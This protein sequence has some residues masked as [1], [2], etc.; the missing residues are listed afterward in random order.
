M[1]FNSS[2]TTKPSLNDN[3]SN[4]K[5]NNI[6]TSKKIL[7]FNNNFL[8]N[9]NNT[10]NNNERCDKFGNLIKKNGKQK[11]SFL[12]KIE[13]RRICEI[14]EIESYKEYNKMNDIKF[15]NNGKNNCCILF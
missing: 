1:S 15:N 11:I 7:N 8:Q 10:I 2:Y 9:K 13:K 14:I 6:D 12:D 5:I 4:N 3:Q